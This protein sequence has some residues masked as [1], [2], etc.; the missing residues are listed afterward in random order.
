VLIAISATL[1]S[2]RRSRR[3]CRKCEATGQR[4]LS[5][6]CPTRPRRFFSREMS[7]LV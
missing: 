1:R 4:Q 5:A 2:E 3:R 7:W 6:A